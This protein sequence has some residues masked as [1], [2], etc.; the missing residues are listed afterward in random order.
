M[1]AGPPGPRSEVVVDKSSERVER[2]LA[3]RRQ[4]FGRRDGKP[5]PPS[6]IQRLRPEFTELLTEFVFGE[7]WSRPGLDLRARSIA[8][9]SALAVL[10]R[11]DEFRLHLRAA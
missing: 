10:G 2:G 5:R 1:S 3:I 6:S 9:V 7:V 11:W 4:L 8:T